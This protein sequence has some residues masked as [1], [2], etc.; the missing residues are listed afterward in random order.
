MFHCK[1][2]G[3][4]RPAIDWLENNSTKA[5]GTVIQTGSTSTLILVLHGGEKN[6]S[7]YSC[8]AKNLAGQAFSCEATLK[9]FAYKESRD[10][11]FYA[12]PQNIIASLGDHVVLTCAAEGSAVPEIAWLKDEKKVAN[13][14]AVLFQGKGSSTSALT[15]Q[16]VEKKDSGRYAC[17]ATSHG[18]SVVSWEAVLAIEGKCNSAY[19][20][21]TQHILWGL[22][23][24]DNLV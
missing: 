3:I 19:F 15:I 6:L 7:K 13:G 17:Q 22:I 21:I 20:E 9:V 24:R 8:V 14:N 10:I 18:T 16:S 5:N 2:I 12:Q 23:I 1:A 11:S 4:P